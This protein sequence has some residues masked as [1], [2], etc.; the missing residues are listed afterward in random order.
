MTRQFN[1]GVP[2]TLQ[3]NVTASGTPEQLTA[4]IRLATIAFNDNGAS[5]DTITDSASGFLA[6]GFQPGDQIT[7]SGSASNDGTY[8]IESVVAGT[9]TLLNRNSLTT[10]IAG[11]TIKITAPKAVPDG[12]SVVIKA[13]YGNAGIIHLADSSAKALNTSGGSFTLRN[14]ESLSLQIENIQNI[15]LEATFSGNGVEVMFEKNIQS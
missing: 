14:N 6:A 7:V 15:W 1:L 4:K 3:F 8:V 11:S 5:P 9:I 2:Y 13:K 12:I 10:E